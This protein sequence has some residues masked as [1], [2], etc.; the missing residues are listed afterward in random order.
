MS[1][2]DDR[3]PAWVMPVVLVAVA[4]GIVVVSIVAGN[5][6]HTG[7]IDAVASAP[8]TS[9]PV[10]VASTTTTTPR[11]TILSAE[12]IPKPAPGWENLG[13]LSASVAFPPAADA[14]TVV[15]ALP[16]TVCGSQCRWVLAAIDHET[17][18]VRTLGEAPMCGLWTLSGIWIGDELVVWSSIPPDQKCPS[19]AAYSQEAGR[20]RV[21]DTDF[22]HEAG[23]QVVW[24]GQELISADGLAYRPDT[25]ETKRVAAVGESAMFTGDSV[26][27]PP[28]MHWTGSELLAL[29]SEG[30][31]VADP[32]GGIVDGPAPPIPES[33]RVSMWTGKELLAV[34]GDME[35]A[36]F[37]PAVDR[38]EK[39]GSVPLA[40]PSLV[41]WGAWGF[42]WSAGAGLAFIQACHG[43][44]V[45]DGSGEWKLLPPPTFDFASG[46]VVVSGGYLY[47][48]GSGY[49]RYLRR[50]RLPDL[51]DGQLPQPSPVPLGGQFLDVPSGW[52]VTHSY[53][54]STEF[55]GETIGVEV[56]APGG[57]TCRVGSMYSPEDGSIPLMAKTSVLTRERDGVE[58]AVGETEGDDEGFAHVFIDTQW[59][60]VDVAC[61][62][63]D[64]AETLAARLWDVSG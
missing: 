3:R 34:A 56:T 61:P 46:Q 13:A 40:S 35:A 60:T 44:A 48:I 21:L 17:G 42:E 12:Q 30:V 31:I 59:A 45:W 64:D 28:L 36:V 10:S 8:A 57:G 51:V 63:L 29:G 43:I 50:Y 49:R 62:N 55:A 6:P 22:F 9:V 11:T 39:V 38:W 47:N 53:R 1:E 15:V 24:T 2:L 32:D 19:A 41:C 20:W 5:L 7:D 33:G 23:L 16:P 26:G 18:D 54:K 14:G 52:Q 37:D 4:A 25:G 58:I 27:S